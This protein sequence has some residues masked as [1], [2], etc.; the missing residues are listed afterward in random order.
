ML[1]WSRAKLSLLKYRDTKRKG[2]RND[3]RNRA[4]LV[5][6]EDEGLTLREHYDDGAIAFEEVN[7]GGSSLSTFLCFIYSSDS[8][9]HYIFGP[10]CLKLSTV[11]LVSFSKRDLKQILRKSVLIK[12]FWDMTTVKTWKKSTEI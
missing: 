6:R 5:L 4:K 8:H 9:L 7:L 2:T 10:S 1:W 11:R 3:T 12:C